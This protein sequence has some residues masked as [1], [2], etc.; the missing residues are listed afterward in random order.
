M[1]DTE[2]G[3]STLPLWAS[4]KQLPEKQ[5]VLSHQGKERGLGKLDSC[6]EKIS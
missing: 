3:E 5:S 4:D 1:Q 2:N 6:V